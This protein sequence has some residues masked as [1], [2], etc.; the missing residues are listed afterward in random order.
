M[1]AAG[2]IRHDDPELSLQGAY[3]VCEIGS[4]GT[5]PVQQQQ[6]RATAA[7]QVVQGVTAVEKERHGYAIPCKPAA[8]RNIVSSPRNGVPCGQL[9]AGSAGCVCSPANPGQ[10][11]PS[12]WS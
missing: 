7:D 5:E 1:S 3:L 9:Y 6:G 12:S 8:L 11:L 4:A 10:R 2:K